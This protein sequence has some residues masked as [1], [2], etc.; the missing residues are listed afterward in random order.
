MHETTVSSDLDTI[1]ENIQRAVNQGKVILGPGVELPKVYIAKS[2]K[3][4][5]E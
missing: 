1:Q 3:E 2:P 4:F 5:T